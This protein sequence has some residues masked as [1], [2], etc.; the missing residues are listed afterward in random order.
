[1]AE[2]QLLNDDQTTMEFVVQVLEEIFGK[3][4][5]TAMRIML[6]THR[7]GFGIYGI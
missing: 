7:E 4:R 5:E 1:M 6:E 3:D 2:V